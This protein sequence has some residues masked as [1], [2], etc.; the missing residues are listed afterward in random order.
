MKLIALCGAPG[1]GK[2][3]VQQYLKERYNVRAVDDG[4]PLRD[5]AM[6]HL[7]LSQHAVSTQDGKATRVTFPGGK[8]MLVR[9]ALGEL[10]NRIEDLFGD[11]AIPAM[12]LEAARR[13][14]AAAGLGASIAYCLGS[15]RRSQ[16][17]F[18]KKHGAKVVEIV[19]PGA[20][21][22][23]EFDSYDRSCVD[24]TI[25]NDSSLAALRTRVEWHF[26]PWLQRG[27][28]F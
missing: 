24:L 6:R 20:N 9:E 17:A 14:H 27:L 23:N 18:Y 5:F 8:S 28:T 11:D 25:T 19:R 26:G 15:V 4:H 3:E 12:A 21:I 1:S 2:S 13:E 22:V 10:G 16:G 7:G